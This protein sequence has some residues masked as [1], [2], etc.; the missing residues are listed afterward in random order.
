MTPGK[1][2]AQLG[3]AFH[4]SVTDKNNYPL[5]QKYETPSLGGSKVCLYSRDEQQLIQ[6]KSKLDFIGIPCKLVIDSNHVHPPHFDGQPIVTALGIGPCTK[7][8]TKKILSKLK[9]IK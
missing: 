6:I 8:D 5:I 7:K 9:L 1:L 2:A 3:H 4:Y